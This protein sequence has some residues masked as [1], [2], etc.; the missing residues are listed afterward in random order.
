MKTTANMKRNI[1]K[2]MFGMAAFGIFQ[3]SSPAQSKYMTHETFI[4][5]SLAPVSLIDIDSELG[6]YSL[7]L[8]TAYEAKPAL[9]NW[10]TDAE[11]WSYM[12]DLSDYVLAEEYE[13]ALHIEDWMLEI[14]SAEPK[15]DYTEQIISEERA[16]IEE[17][18]MH[19]ETWGK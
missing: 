2:V 1:L 6:I 15:Q 12:N 11:S 19:P 3:F 9:E 17:W 8:S 7:E 5:S 13:E 10:M 18:M 16:P 14:S 4:I